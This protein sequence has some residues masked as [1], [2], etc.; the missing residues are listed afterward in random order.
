MN[1]IPKL[2][3]DVALLV[4]RKK[5]GLLGKAALLGGA[6]AATLGI[7]QAM[8]A[9]R[10]AAPV[11]IVEPAP[12]MSRQEPAPLILKA[13]DTPVQMAGH[14]SHRSH[15]SHSSHRSHSS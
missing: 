6:V 9:P 11:S 1:D 3:K 8:P 7:G 13:I 14:S 12:V 15:S 10:P 2:D 4:P 5:L